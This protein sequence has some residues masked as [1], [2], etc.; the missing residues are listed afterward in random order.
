MLLFGIAI[1]T[2]EN[3]QAIG[4][5][6][7]GRPHLGAVEFPAAIHFVGKGLH[8]AQHVRAAIG[9]GHG[10]RYAQV[11]RRHVGQPALLLFLSAGDRDHLCSAEGGQ[12]PY[13]QQA[14]R[15]AR[16]FAREDHLHDD[17][18]AKPAIFFGDTNTEETLFLQLVPDFIGIV[19]LVGLKLAHEILGQFGIHP[20][21][22]D[23]AKG[24]LF[25]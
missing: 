19:F 7:T 2:G 18:A 25:F 14:A 3:E 4:R 12:A 16:H 6:G 9:F 1:G 5:L 8:R 11:A 22:H 24:G 21:T 23:V 10:K 20:A 13:P 15:R 17:I